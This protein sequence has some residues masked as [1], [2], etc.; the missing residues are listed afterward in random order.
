MV[1]DSP[2]GSGVALGSGDGA[3]GA[4]GS[5]IEVNSVAWVTDWATTSPSLRIDNAARRAVV[6]RGV[7][8]VAVRASAASM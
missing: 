8:V 6:S 1:G 7:D 4:G 3:L 5:D 2:G